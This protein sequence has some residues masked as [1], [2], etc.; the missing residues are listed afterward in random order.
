MDDTIKQLLGDDFAKALI[1]DLGLEHETP[2]AQ[3]YLVS[4]LGQNVFERITLEVLN[5]LPETEYENF[6][7]L[8]KAGDMNALRTF[9]EKH[10]P[11]LDGFIQKTARAE[12]EATK[13]LLGE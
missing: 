3:A 13:A 12:Y 10:I 1:R 5:T 2:E 11:N 8:T 4:S 7:A 9:L 6:S